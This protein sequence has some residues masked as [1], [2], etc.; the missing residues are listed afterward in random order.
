MV[1]NIDLGDKD[2][3]LDNAA[4]NIHEVF[5]LYQK[6]ELGVRLREIYQEDIDLPSSRSV[7]IDIDSHDASREGRAQGNLTQHRYTITLAVNLWYYHEEMEENTRK[8]DVMNMVWKITK[9]F[10]SHTT[11]NGFCPK[12][13]CEIAGGEYLPRRRG[14]KIMAAGLVRL[15]LTKLYTVTNLD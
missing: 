9:M 12:L 5:K 13:G 2:N 6:D 4:A 15:R 14:S 11:V 8:K 10:M 1:R 3:I 7:A